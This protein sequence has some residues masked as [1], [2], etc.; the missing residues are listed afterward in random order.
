MSTI[1]GAA[2]S[3]VKKKKKKK[4]KAGQ[5]VESSDSDDVADAIIED[6]D[7]ADEGED[8]DMRREAV[9]SALKKTMEVLKR[10]K[11]QALKE[12]ISGAKK[13][14]VDATVIKAAEKRL[15]DHKHD[16]RRGE[17]ED[18]LNEFMKTDQFEDIKAC[19]KME[20]KAEKADV[21]DEDLKQLRDKL[22]LLRICRELE[23]DEDDTAYAMVQKSASEFFDQA[24]S[25][26]GRRVI[27]FDHHNGSKCCASLTLDPPVRHLILTL[28]MTD[29][30]KVII[31][32]T[33][34]AKVFCVVKN[35]NVEG[36]SL[37]KLSAGEHELAV[38]VKHTGE[39]ISPRHRSPRGE[40]IQPERTVGEGVW[41]FVEAT[42]PR[43]DR[44]FEAIMFLQHLAAECS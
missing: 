22:Y 29:Q 33:L 24:I 26:A 34:L 25:E 13:L 8:E 36:I 20:S 16:Q 7:S 12:A 11:T 2:C 5:L 44:L 4:L 3:D 35:F 38:A 17:V 43:R 30:D 31:K 19:V 39:I 9:E 21:R 18:E 41:I 14:K 10:G 40:P 6:P 28:E 32:K 15:A 27:F 37:S 23:D 42:V 1:M